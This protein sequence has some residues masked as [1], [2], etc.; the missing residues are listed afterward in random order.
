[1]NAL[2]PV[3]EYFA[4]VS[5]QA[6]DVKPPHRGKVELLHYGDYVLVRS[7]I[8]GRLERRWFHQETPIAYYYLPKSSR[9]KLV[10][11]MYNS[12]CS[13]KEIAELIGISTS[14]ITLDIKE[15]KAHHW[16]SDFSQTKVRDVTP[17]D[18]I[19]KSTVNQKPIVGNLVTADSW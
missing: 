6:M 4:R 9:L 17:P 2:S 7:E 14:T 8:E 11:D 13:I 16:C 5:Q 19:L 18:L 3:Y 10:A 15:A 12:G 1:M